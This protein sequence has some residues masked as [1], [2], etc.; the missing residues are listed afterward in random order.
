MR[1]L[2]GTSQFSFILHG[3]TENSDLCLCLVLD[4]QV[5]AFECVTCDTYALKKSKWIVA[6][7]ASNWCHSITRKICSVDVQV[8]GTRQFI[9]KILLPKILSVN[10]DQGEMELNTDSMREG[11]TVMSESAI[12]LPPT[13]MSRA[14][15]THSNPMLMS[16]D[17]NLT[18]ETHNFDLIGGGGGDGLANRKKRKRSRTMTRSQTAAKKRRT[19]A[20]SRTRSRSNLRKNKAE[21]G[22][23]VC[24]VCGSKQNWI[25]G[26]SK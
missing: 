2:G 10:I 26:N 3:I 16:V 21:R 23:Y 22:H 11:E 18:N 5:H 20:L 24:S 15:S 13:F 19:E 6:G 1:Q 17:M 4:V 12:V 9:E 14:N 7:V 25:S 8:D